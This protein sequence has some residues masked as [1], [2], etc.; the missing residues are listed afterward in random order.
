M[1]RFWIIWLLV[2]LTAGC[3]RQGGLDPQRM[4]LADEAIAAAIDSGKIPGAVLA[5]V[6]GGKTVYLKAYG[7][8]QVVPDTLPMTTDAIFD[9]ASLSKCVG[10]TPAV[11]QLVE[12]GRIG[13]EDSVSQYIPDFA[14]WRDPTSGESVEIRI[15]D[16]LNH[17]AGL[18]PEIDVAAYLESFGPFT[19]DSLMHHIATELPR[20]FRPSTDG[21][22]YSCLNFITLQHVVEIVSGEPL[23]DFARR[24][25]F[26]KLGMDHTGYRPVLHPEWMEKVVPT[27]LQED[28]LPLCGEVHDPTARL[29]ND[30][31]SGN[32]GVF[33]P[34]EDLVLFAKALFNGGAYRGRRILSKKTVRL[35]KEYRAP[36]GRSLGWDAESTSSG[37][38]GDGFNPH[39]V[40][41]H[42]GYTGTSMVL[43]FETET[44]VILLSNRVHPWDQGGIGDLRKTISNIVAASLK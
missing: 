38:K 7:N 2:L 10:T 24:N 30:G 39:T 6:R 40:L 31:N 41:C 20:N 21:Y 12:Q 16:L 36:N 3:G 5:V 34:A 37:L 19:P 29:V 28:G 4:A 11:L 18:P 42:T 33:A 32:A 9:L 13:L 27:T 15:I 14:P 26:E 44:A 1:K 35:M 25:I 22:L 43:D 17:S 23:C 8:R